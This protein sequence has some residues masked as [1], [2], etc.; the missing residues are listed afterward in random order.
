MKK[1]HYDILGVGKNAD[2]KQIKEAYRRLARKLHPDVNRSK[3]AAERM[4]DLN[5]A[6]D[7]LRDAEQKA[8]YD[9]QLRTGI[10]YAP[11][12]TRSSGSI[13]TRHHLT[14]TDLPSPVYS[15]GFSPDESQV[16]I[17]CFDN[18]LRFAS[19]KTGK[20]LDETALDG[21]AVS[22]LCW[23]SRDNIIAAGAGER[24]VTIWKLSKRKVV[25]S[26]SKRFEWVSQLAA[27]A[28]GKF[29]ALGSV[30]KTVMLIDSETG[31]AIHQKR[32]HEDAVT[33]LCISRDSRILASG[34][35]D[36]RVI[37]WDTHTGLELSHITLRAAI[38]PMAFSPDGSLLAVS[39]IDAGIRV[40]ELKSGALR[41]TLWGHDKAVEA[42]AFHP[43]GTFL[44]SASRDATT[45]IWNTSKGISAA[46]LAGHTGPVKAAAFS[47]KGSFLGSGGLDSAVSLWRTR[48]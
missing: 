40:Y 16:A 41:S 2:Q 29:V 14:I 37:L 44:A 38:G 48:A 11:T 25:S 6:Y 46:K 9:A 21:G 31:A 32:K 35:N 26:V 33:S 43:G 7:V 22:S 27:S 30:H 17:G 45:R 39:L 47:P 19:A 20:S 3:D 18:T 36:Q 42:L 15:L 34:G 13:Y 28:N 4:S 24:T 10:P 5:E 23:L 12:P 1:T 8:S